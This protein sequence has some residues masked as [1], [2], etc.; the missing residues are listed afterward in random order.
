VHDLAISFAAWIAVVST[1]AT[2]VAVHVS[3]T[4]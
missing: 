1:V 3:A 4:R 2:A